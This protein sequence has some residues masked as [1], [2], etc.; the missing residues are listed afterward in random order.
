MHILGNRSFSSHEP[1]FN[2]EIL[3]RLIDIEEQM[4]EQK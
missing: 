1:A 3:L 2:P 4:S